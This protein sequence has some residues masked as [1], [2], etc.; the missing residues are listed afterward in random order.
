MHIMMIREERD[1]RGKGGARQNN[2]VTGTGVSTDKERTDKGRG[3]EKN[4][5]SA[6]LIHDRSQLILKRLSHDRWQIVH[7]SPGYWSR[8]HVV[9]SDG[10][11]DDSVAGNDELKL[12][13]PGIHETTPFG[14]AS[15]KRTVVSD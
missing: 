9:V 13:G 7:L 10:W 11:G 2:T 12:T 15:Q 1:R 14:V 5:R 6:H 3:A 4:K 8:E